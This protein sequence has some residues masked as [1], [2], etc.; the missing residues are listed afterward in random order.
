MYTIYVHN[1][2]MCKLCE[3]SFTGTGGMTVAGYPTE[4]AWLSRKGDTFVE[5]ELV[6]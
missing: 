6:V 1:D 3:I 5:M 4:Y 2:H